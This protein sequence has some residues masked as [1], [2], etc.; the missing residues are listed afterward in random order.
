LHVLFVQRDAFGGQDFTARR[1]FWIAR[2]G[3]LALAWARRANFFDFFCMP[4][5]LPCFA[6]LQDLLRLFIL[7]LSV[8]ACTSAKS[9]SDYSEVGS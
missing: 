8:V 5:S 9:F 1:R 2:I 7:R 6:L 3:L 4:N